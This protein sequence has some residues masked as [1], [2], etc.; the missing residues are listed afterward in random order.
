MFNMRYYW[1]GPGYSIFDITGW[2]HQIKY[3]IILAGPRVFNI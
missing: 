3:P 2:A 1:L